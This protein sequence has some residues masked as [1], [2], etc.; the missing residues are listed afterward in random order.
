[1]DRWPE[2]LQ[3]LLSM[4]VVLTLG[5]L[6][7]TACFWAF[8]AAGWN[9]R[10]DYTCPPGATCHWEKSGKNGGYLAR[11]CPTPLVLDRYITDKQEHYI[12]RE[13]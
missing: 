6:L 5:I 12:C 4:A 1:M 2:P 3:Y 9:Y 7:F 10:Y 8:D 11:V 13:P